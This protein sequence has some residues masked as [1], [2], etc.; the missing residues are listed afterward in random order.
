MLILNIDPWTEYFAMWGS[1]AR[2]TR[3]RPTRSS[4]TSRTP[5]G[6][7]RRREGCTERWTRKQLRERGRIFFFSARGVLNITLTLARYHP[8]P[9]RSRDILRLSCEETREVS[10]QT[11]DSVGRVRQDS[12]WRNHASGEMRREA[13]RNLLRGWGKRV[14]TADYAISN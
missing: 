4:S 5:G 10:R 11:P 7:D 13:L 9:A 1:R 8:F 2:Q 14:I 3:E 6:P 12:H